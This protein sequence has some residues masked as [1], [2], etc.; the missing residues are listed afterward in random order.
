MDYMFKDASMNININTKTVNNSLGSIQFTA[1]DTS[2][3]TTMRGMFSGSTGFN[4]QLTNWNTSNVLSI[5]Y[6][7]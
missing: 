5:V 3:V 1:W 7:L 6:V 4:Q 2:N